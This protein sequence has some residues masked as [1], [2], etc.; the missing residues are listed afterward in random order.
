MTEDLNGNID[1]DT[2]YDVKLNSVVKDCNG[3][4]E[5]PFRTLRNAHCSL[6][7]TSLTHSRE[8]F[9]KSMRVFLLPTPNTGFKICKEEKSGFAYALF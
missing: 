3:S 6:T 7:A 9:Q 8:T 1:V 5:S 2:N 4:E